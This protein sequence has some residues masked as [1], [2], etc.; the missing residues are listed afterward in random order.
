MQ[1]EMEE[2]A[3][4]PQ[5][6]VVVVVVQLLQQQMVIMAI[7]EHTGMA[8]LAVPDREMVEMEEIL[9]LQEG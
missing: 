3:T 4:L 8:V 7:M 2:N 9:V 1:E 5:E 6:Q